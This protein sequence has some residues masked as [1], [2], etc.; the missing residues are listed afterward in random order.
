MGTWFTYRMYQTLPSLAEFGSIEPPL[1][2]KVYDKDSTLFHEFSV[3]KRFWVSLDEI[4]EELQKAVISTLPVK[5]QKRGK[6]IFT[7]RN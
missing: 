4:P 6:I 2:S 7:N 3:E 1:A 5:I